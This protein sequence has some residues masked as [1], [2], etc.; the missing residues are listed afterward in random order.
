[1]AADKSDDGEISGGSLLKYLG[2]FVIASLAVVGLAFAMMNYFMS[3]REFSEFKNRMDNELIQLR[4]VQ[5]TQRVSRSE[6]ENEGK[7]HEYG[8]N[9]LQKQIEDLME[10]RKELGSQRLDDLQ[11]RINA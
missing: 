4:N 2:S 11:K 9:M 3:V 10:N 5:N 6:F 8:H 1:M 7:A